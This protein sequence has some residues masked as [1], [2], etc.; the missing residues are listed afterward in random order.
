VSTINYGRTSKRDVSAKTRINGTG[1]VV[2]SRGFSLI[3]NRDGYTWKTMQDRA[4]NY[5]IPPTA[6]A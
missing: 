6:N 4:T 3:S 2:L 5:A 1:Q